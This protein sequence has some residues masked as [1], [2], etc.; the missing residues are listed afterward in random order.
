MEKEKFSLKDQLFNEGK[1]IKIANDIAR[2]YPAFKKDKFI[3]N[4]VQSFPELELKQ[5]ITHITECLRNHLPESYAEALEIILNSLPEPCSPKLNDN[6]FG[7]FIYAA[8]GHFVA[9]FG[10]SEE[11][12]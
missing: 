4:V 10:C 6:D 7:D 1:I 2:V 8:H 12:L 5:R 11:F 9:Q 3:K